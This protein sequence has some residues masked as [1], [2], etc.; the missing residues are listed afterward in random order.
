MLLTDS[1]TFLTT[2][3]ACESETNV[4]TC[5][6]KRMRTVEGRARGNWRDLKARK[7]GQ[8]E[9]VHLLHS[10]GRKCVKI[11]KMCLDLKSKDQFLL[12]ND[13]IF[14]C[15]F[16]FNIILVYLDGIITV[17]IKFIYFFLYLKKTN[18]CSYTCTND[19]R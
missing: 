19:K 16:V 11:F 8:K 5:P 12:S 6:R 4:K 9:C 13:F 10:H 15:S 1:C 17:V 2:S 14:V 3:A 7:L 18:K